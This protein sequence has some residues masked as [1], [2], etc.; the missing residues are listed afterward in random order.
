MAVNVSHLLALRGLGH[1]QMFQEQ[2]LKLKMF[3]GISALITKKY[4]VSFSI[5]YHLIKQDAATYNHSYFIAFCFVKIIST[6]M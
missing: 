4:R 3:P 2:Q 6:M 5:Q 1:K